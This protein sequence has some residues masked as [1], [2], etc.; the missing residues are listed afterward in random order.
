MLDN[1]DESSLSKA[2][3][4]KLPN[5]NLKQTVAELSNDHLKTVKTKFCFKIVL[6]FFLRKFSHICKTIKDS[7]CQNSK[8]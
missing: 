7:M 1:F 6:T 3:G 8:K 5:N 2:L 4:F